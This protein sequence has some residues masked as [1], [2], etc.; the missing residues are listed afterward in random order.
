M[1]RPCMNPGTT[2]DSIAFLPWEVLDA[3]LHSPV[4]AFNHSIAE[5]LRLEKT[6][7]T[8]K[9]NHQPIT[10][11]PTN[12]V[13]QIRIAQ[14]CSER[15]PN[16]C[17]QP[18]APDQCYS[19]SVKE[20]SLYLVFLQHEAT[21]TLGSSFISKQSSVL[22]CFP[23]DLNTNKKLIALTESFLCR[24]T[25]I[26]GSLHHASSNSRLPALHSCQ[27]FP[28][29]FPSVGVRR[30]FSRQGSKSQDCD[31]PAVLHGW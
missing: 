8:I 4:K 2:A 23:R 12:H 11:V 30:Y 28:L 25:F 29:P 10:T 3:F 31:K 15:S 20:I 18:T 22:F 24:S 1:L 7:K 6:T 26:N 19:E 21:K 5:S 16:I 14:H 9:S 13:S 17:F 27:I